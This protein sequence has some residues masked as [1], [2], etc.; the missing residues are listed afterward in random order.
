MRLYPASA[1]GR[2]RT[3][4]GDL[5]LVLLLVLFAWLGMKVHDAIADLAGI[6]RGIQDSG[7]QIAATTRE[8]AGAIDG[9]FNGAAGKVEGLPLVGGDL[10]NSL[11]EAPRGATDPIRTTGDDTG[12]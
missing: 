10:A 2:T 8:T 7:R 11:R 3:L 4:A 5:T 12:A 1:G 9:A 6:G